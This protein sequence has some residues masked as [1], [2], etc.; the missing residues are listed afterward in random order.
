MSAYKDSFAKADKD[1]EREIISY[2]R[3][4]PNFFDSYQDILTDMNLLH[5]TGTAISLIERQVMVLRDQKDSLKQKLDSLIEI[6]KQND[7]L[8]QQFNR[9]ILA[10]LDAKNLDQVIDVVQQRIKVD[11]NADSVVLRLFAKQHAVLK[12]R[13]VLT[14]W[15][16]PVMGA[17]EKVINGSKP[18]CGRL[19]HGHLES[20]F[21]DDEGKICSA[22][23]IPLMN[24]TDKSNRIGLL[25]IGSM[26]RNRFKADMGI[27][28]LSHLGQVLSRVL[29]L[30]L[31]EEQDA[32]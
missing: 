17:F 13:P 1:I 11:F 30:H 32:S 31:I 10:L 26:E 25:A 28:F 29:E 27:M 6:A 20:L 4:H 14:D 3:D 8:S 18:V 7:E 9:L 2:L 22:A 15:T 23:L 16:D 21:N 12:A 5:D 19:G 24:D